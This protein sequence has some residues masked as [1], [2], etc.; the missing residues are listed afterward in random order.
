MPGSEF[1][2]NVVQQFLDLF[3]T[4]EIQRRQREEGAER[5]FRLGRAQIIFF[6]DGRRPEVRLN[7]EVNIRVKARFRDQKQ[8]ENA[9][10]GAS[11]KWGDIESIERT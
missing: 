2:R 4:P 3:V 7:D 6:P 5:P 8:Q 1:N 10:V 9:T 11:I